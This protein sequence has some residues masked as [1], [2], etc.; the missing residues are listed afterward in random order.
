[1]SSNFGHFFA[2]H[3]WVVF[4]DLF[5]AVFFVVERAVVLIGVPVSTAERAPT[6]TRKACTRDITSSILCINALAV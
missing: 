4:A 5:S 3:L 6:P 1:M 2:D